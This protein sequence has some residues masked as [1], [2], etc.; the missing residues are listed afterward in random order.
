MLSPQEEQHRGPHD[1]R[2]GDV[3]DE[4]GKPRLRQDGAAARREEEDGGAALPDAPQVSQSL[5]QCEF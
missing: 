1:V 3:R 4:P 5:T 2:D